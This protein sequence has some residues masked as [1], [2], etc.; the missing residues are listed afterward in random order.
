MPITE[1]GLFLFF[2]NDFS[3]IV[4][5]L[6]FKQYLLFSVFPDVRISLVA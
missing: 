3:S 4:D 2:A 1:G 6:P 5:I